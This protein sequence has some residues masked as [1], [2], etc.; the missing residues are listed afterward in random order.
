MKKFVDWLDF[1]RVAIVFAAALLC[2]AGVYMYRLLPK[3]VF[4]NSEFPRFQVVADIGFASLETTELNITRPLEEALQTVPGVMEVRSVTERGTSTI[5]IYLKWGT[6]LNQALQYLQSRID[7][8]RVLMPPGA[9]I[10]TTKMTTSAYPMSEY[11]VWSDTLTLKELY[12]TVRYSAIPRLIGVDG[13]ARLDVVGA[14][15][16][17]IWVKLNP[18]KLAGYNLD[19]QAIAAAVGDI[20]NLSFIGTV[21]GGGKTMFAVGG[22]RLA[23]AADIG[24]VVIASRMGRAVRLSDVA[25]LSEGRAEVR[26]LVSINGHKG[27]FIDV[28]KQGDA[29][30]LR[31]GSDL[32][33]KFA[34][35]EKEYGGKL[36]VAK[37]DLSDFVRESIQGILI[38]IILGVLIILSIVYYVMVRLRYSLPIML[39]VPIVLVVEFLALK[40][41]GLTVNIM[42]LGGLAAAIG[43]IADNAIVITESYVR[44]RAE[45]K[46]DPLASSMRYIAPITIWATL[47]SIVVF[48]PLTLLSGVPGLFFK[49]LALTLASTIIISLVMALCLLPVLIYY[50]IERNGEAPAEEKE[51][52]LFSA[53]KSGYLKLITLALTRRKTVAAVISAL[54]LAGVIVFLRLPTGFLP[55][56]DEGDIVFDYQAES[57][58]SLEAVDKVMVK[59]EAIV[60]KV[61]ELKLYVRKTG[62]HLGTPFAPPTV[63]EI[64]ILLNPDRAR[65]TFEIMDD[66]RAKVEKEFPDLD[67]DF[68]QILPDRLGD[69]TGSAKPIVVS[70]V[71]NNLDKAWELARRVQEKLEKIDGLN[72]VLVNLPAAQ[73]EIRVVP[74]QKRLS[75][76]GLSSADA[77]RYSG[78]ALYGET[79]TSVARGVQLIPVRAMYAGAFRSDASALGRIP[80][81]TPNGGVLPLDKLMAFSSAEQVPEVHHKN[82][83]IVVSVN[84]EIGDR[85]LGDA[86]GDVKAALAGMGSADYSIELEG[87]Y[88]EQQ[89]SFHELLLVL[90]FSA[91]LILLCLLFIFESYLTS[92]AVFAGTLASTTFVVFGLKLAGIEFDVSSF[93]GMITVMGIVVNNGI[94]VIAFAERAANAG[95]APAAAVMEA[96]TLRFRPVLITNLA[97]IAGFLPMALN[98]GKGGEVLRPF[99]VAM[100]SGL[101]GAMFFSLVAIPV[102]YLFLHERGKYVGK[103]VRGDEHE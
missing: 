73:K 68:H 96:C 58:M 9:A 80:V 66:L 18:E 34:Q 11:G 92:L 99:S 59:V 40:A 57:G 15:E 38:D 79:V 63:G 8:A 52:R 28:L 16:P 62:T 61:P 22:S 47:V 65:S 36:H 41:M 88:K 95:L 70:V 50:F 24:G 13:V 72:G 14:E 81:Y 89:N 51:R 85:P 46:P 74:D 78:L 55:E 1:N 77:F 19:Y 97:A 21:S 98:I 45:G 10:Q 26:R 102:F 31:L 100:I 71:G 29:D 5:D 27:L 67:T 6:D 20:N 60:A 94:L 53:L 82:G 43:I 90:V 86:I 54:L 4:P 7:Q 56:W 91:L 2:A 3:D 32:D 44:F 83:S 17:E 103:A 84:A 64:V 39:I 12:T 69:L 25:E 30:G 37:W 35:L 48:V 87:N 49:P 23:G 75:L 93:T 42:T 76:L 101:V 33:A